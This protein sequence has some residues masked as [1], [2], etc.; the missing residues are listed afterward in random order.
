VPV[1]LPVVRIVT[2]DDGT[3]TV[4]LDGTA[5]T[6]TT[7]RPVTDPRA[8]VREIA[9]DLDTPLRVEVRTADGRTLTDLVTP[10]DVAPPPAPTV[11][12]PLDPIVFGVIGSGFTPGEAVSVAV[13]VSATTASADGVAGLRLPTALL[14]RTPKPFILLGADSRTVVVSDPAAATAGAA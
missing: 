2:A 9:T 14:A 3:L 8:V 12:E 4:T 1:S 13:V 11:R 10:Q 7:S 5:W 6:S